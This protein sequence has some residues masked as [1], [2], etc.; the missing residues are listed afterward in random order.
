MTS[1]WRLVPTRRHS[2][3]RWIQTLYITFTRVGTLA[4]PVRVAGT[5]LQAELGPPRKPSYLIGLFVKLI[6]QI[7]AMKQIALTARTAL[8]E[9]A[10]LPRNWCKKNL[11]GHGKEDVNIKASGESQISIVLDVK[12]ELLHRTAHH[13]GAEVLTSLDMSIKRNPPGNRQL[14]VQ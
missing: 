5:A 12:S 8:T 9:W 13:T 10:R 6:A 11:H 1:R 3:S 2:S 7:K 14:L 4:N